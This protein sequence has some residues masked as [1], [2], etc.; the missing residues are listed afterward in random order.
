MT[1]Q[2][3]ITAI[4]N[5]ETFKQLLRLGAVSY[6]PNSDKLNPNVGDNL[7]NPSV[8]ED[9]LIQLWDGQLSCWGAD[10]EISGA[11]SDVEVG[12]TFEEIWDALSVFESNV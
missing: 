8:G 3:A 11:L 4:E 12:A 10:K 6:G 2:S 9:G 7:F 5:T 1:N